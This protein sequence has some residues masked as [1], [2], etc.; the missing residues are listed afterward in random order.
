[1][2]NHMMIDLETLG[3]NDEA[4]PPMFEIGVVVFDYKNRNVVEKRQFDLCL[5]DVILSTGFMPQKDTVEWWRQQDYDP[6]SLPRVGLRDSL[7]TISQM[8]ETHK[9]E[10]VWGNSPRFDM[11]ILVKHYRAIGLKEPWTHRDELD[12]R[13]VRKLSH[14]EEIGEPEE[15]EGFTGHHALSDAEY[16]TEKLQRYIEGIRRN[17]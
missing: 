4:D 13:T 14:L 6:R 10:F 5:L 11:A 3:L 8:W 2:S 9:C 15:P 1:M 16:Q 17:V 12:Y 7:L